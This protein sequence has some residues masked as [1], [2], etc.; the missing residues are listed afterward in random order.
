MFVYIFLIVF[1]FLLSFVKQTKT[2]ERFAFVV[3]AFILCFGYMTGSDWRMYE[4]W[5]E[6]KLVY[7]EEILYGILSDFFRFIGVGFWTFFTLLKVILLAVFFLVY[8]RFEAPLFFCMML[9]IAMIGLYLFID[10]PMRSLI[11]YAIFAYSTKYIV[12]RDFWKYLLCTIIAVGFHQSAIIVLPLY[13]LYRLEMKNWVLIF[14][15]V[16]VNI[17]FVSQQA[18]FSI[19]EFIKPYIPFAGDLIA[20]YTSAVRAHPYLAEFDYQVFSIGLAI[21]IFWFVVLLYYKDRI[22]EQFKYG[23][24]VLMLAFCA[25][26]LSRITLTVPIFVRVT[27]FFEVF[28]IVAIGYLL[29]LLSKR[30]RMVVKIILLAYTLFITQRLVT[31]DFRYIPY[32]NVIIHSIRGDRPSYEERSWHN[33]RHSPHHIEGTEYFV[34]H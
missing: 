21:K 31:S 33:F 11:T 18:V 25:I 3:I 1:C 20:K 28:Y 8:K 26:I 23:K 24:L 9:F 16:L 27:L 2:V 4:L 34:Y 17:L 22:I 15:L 32:T 5:Y 7:E 10:N 13:F 29:L 19:I 14:L 6:Q 30:N 12:S